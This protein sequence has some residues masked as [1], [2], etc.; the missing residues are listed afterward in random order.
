[1]KH[2]IKKLVRESLL[3]EMA[4]GFNNLIDGTGLFTHNVNNGYDFVLY[5]PS[6]HH[7]YGI[8]SL[9][10]SDF[11]GDSFFVAG[12]AAEKGFGPFMY[13]LAMMQGFI[14]NRGL[15]PSRDG[16]IRPEAWKV[17]EQFFNRTDI[18]K[19]ELNIHDPD[20]RVDIIEDGKYQFKRKGEI[21]DFINEIT[22]EDRHI[23]RVFN[24]I[25]S[26]KPTNEFTQLINTAKRLEK[27]HSVAM[28]SGD[29]FWHSKYS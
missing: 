9:S 25:Y 5:N 18:I 28:K 17:W 19:K 20:F 26:I 13:E 12:V 23:L 24:T 11:Y 3:D 14:D 7:V 21:D 4:M 29:D 10:Q 6:T 22:D 15:M 1:M 27:Y 8:I 2:L 16:D